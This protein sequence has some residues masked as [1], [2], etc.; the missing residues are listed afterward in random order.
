MAKFW[1]F[2]QVDGGRELR[3][4]GAISDV[5]WL[6]DEVTPK[7]FRDELEAGDGDITVW[8]NSP[9]GDVF[10]ATEI[11]NMLKAYR[12]RVTV[13]IDSLAASAAS[14][15]AMAG[16]TV[17]ISA[18]GMMMIHNPAT[19]AAGD[20]GEMKL[21]AQMLDEVKEGIINAYE[22]KTKMPRERLSDMMTAETWLNANKAVELG[23]ADKIIDDQR[24]ITNA[25]PAQMF[26][27]M[28][29]TNS[30]ATAWRARR[31]EDKPPK[32]ERR[33]VVSRLRDRL[34]KLEKLE[35]ER[36]ET[37]YRAI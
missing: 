5:T 7:K 21:A 3:L 22:T 36:N 16:D 10:A 1:N 19:I 25:I 30:L 37:Q 23:F 27:Q 13:K 32:D 34:E 2:A 18:C 11:Y 24:G 8:I 28:Q 17:E 6:G 29:V 4:D 20:A 12:G 9:G 26:S 33:V 31:V 35:S 14:V 15:V